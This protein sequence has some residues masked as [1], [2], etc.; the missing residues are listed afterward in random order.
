[1]AKNKKPRKQYHKRWRKQK[2]IYDPKEVDSIKETFSDVE[3]AVEMKLPRGMMS[4]QDV[5]ELRDMINLSTIL[6]F[7]GYGIEPSYCQKTYGEAWG[8]MQDAFHSYYTR[9]CD[10]N[11]FTATGDELNSIREGIT[12]A[13]VIMQKTLDADPFRVAVC[14]GIV[15]EKATGGQGRIQVSMELIERRI[16]ELQRA[17]HGTKGV[18]LNARH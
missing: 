10:K 9:A 11:I 6:L 13:G 15:K 8:R 14:Y 5:Q 12:I 2:L 18:F 17:E 4:M 1:M 16:R 3:L 7:H